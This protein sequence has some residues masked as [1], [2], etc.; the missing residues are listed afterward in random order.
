MQ[1]L[2]PGHVRVDR[3]VLQGDADAAAHR[4]GLAHEVV[5]GHPGA[6]AGGPQEGGQHPHGGALAGAVRPEE[7]VHLAARR[8]RRSTPSTARMSPLKTRSSPSASTAGRS[9]RPIGHPSPPRRCSPRR[10][11]RAFRHAWAAAGRSLPSP[12]CP[13]RRSVRGSRG[14]AAPAARGGR[15]SALEQRDLARDGEERG[16]GHHHPA[17]AATDADLRERDLREQLRWKRARGAP[18]GRPRGDRGGDL[19]DL[20]GLRRGDPGGTAARAA[21]RRPLR[22]LPAG[23]VPAEVIRRP[24]RAGHPA[25]GRQDH[26]PHEGGGGHVQHH[27]LPREPVA[28]LVLA[29]PDLQRHQGEGERGEAA[30]EAIDARPRARPT[31]RARPRGPR[32]PRP[33]ARARARPAAG[34]P[35]AG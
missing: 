5:A 7:A 8:R 26:G 2:A 34:R 33:S 4:A 15:P 29:D 24:G 17:E 30:G 27:H 23:V 9:L 16:D 25:T 11:A 21:G 35:S 31:P 13:R 19:R 22:P 20:R 18:A 14:A 3:R 32:R 12:R 28:V 1:Q 10:L 6:P